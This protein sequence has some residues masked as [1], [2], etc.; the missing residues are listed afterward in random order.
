M[1]IF[2]VLILLCLSALPAAAQDNKVAIR[3]IADRGQI[4]AGESITVGIEQTIAPHW[5]TYWINPGDSGT[6][7]RI[8]WTLP[9]GFEPADIQWPVPQK[10]PFGP[11][12]NFGYENKAVL[13]QEISAPDT[14]GNHPVT[15][16]ADIEILV[17]NEVCIPE[18]HKATLTLNDGSAG[19]P[20]AIAQARAALPVEMGWEAKM[21]KGEGALITA[22]TTDPGSRFSSQDD[23]DILPEEWGL[24]DNTADAT[25][26]LDE[27]GG[28]LT[29]HKAGGDRDLGD[30][31]VTKAI[32]T[33]KADDG[34][35]RGIRISVLNPSAT[36]TTPAH[37]AAPINTLPLWQVALL[38]LLGGLVL[39]L[40]PCVFP[41]LSMKALSL[42]NM[43]DK[44]IAKTRL[45]GLSYTAGVVGS[46]VTIAAILIALKSAGA[47]IGWGFQLQSPLIILILA[48][49]LFLIGLNLSG[50]FEFTGRFANIGS[51][52]TAKAGYGGSFFTGVL[53]TI[54]ATPCTAP[55]M[56]V[57]MGVALTLPAPQALGIFIALGVGLALPYLLLTFVPALRHLLPRPGAWMETFR[58][59]LAFP[60]YA[61]AAWLVWVLA[62]QAD[63]MAVLSALLGMVAIAFVLWLYKVRPAKGAPR[64][65]TFLL[66]LA[67]L[68]FVISTLILPHPEGMKQKAPHVAALDQ[69]WED[70][71]QERLDALLADGY[72]VF[73]NMTAAWC[74]TCKVNEKV[75]LS[76]DSTRAI[77]AEKGIRYIKGD[78]TNQNPEITQYLASHGRSGVPI[79]VYYGP[80]DE[81]TGQRPDP[82]I[83]P[84]LLT[85]G[86][87]H[88]AVQVQ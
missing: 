29:I 49:L 51:S 69:N 25:V 70:F 20:S 57:A 72:P 43:K 2:A 6:A 23:I 36:G 15:L 5:H 50:F 65:L 56:G 78:W 66:A 30:V 73:V 13:L 63:P 53:A 54:V 14:L 42:A 68:G 16:T 64:I 60:M 77:F 22:I 1:R 31:A 71:T 38:A 85:P 9:D 27:D 62:Q 12:V 10:L 87:V 39:N 18:T 58:Q 21:E 41:V 83:L 76:I 80:R 17:C 24:I 52:L 19:S 26:T 79:Y 61:S 32:L 37:A 4:E 74:I 40:M 75:A 46:F 8:V 88:E 44:D 55:F 86:I 45:H 82:V 3:L 28:G 81:T 34:S 11:M 47:Q 67:T 33:Y 35:R 59:F 48:Y 84:Q 7:P